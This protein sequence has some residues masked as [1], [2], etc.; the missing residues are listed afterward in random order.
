M[1]NTA[2]TAESLLDVLTEAELARYGEIARDQAMHELRNWGVQAALGVAALASASW[3]AAGLGCGC[4][5]LG[6]YGRHVGWALG[7]AVALGYWPYRRLKNWSLWRRHVKAV[8]A[9]QARRQHI[10]GHDGS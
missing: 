3:A 9:A 2:E 1:P 5:D 10:A 4:V 6:G 7:A 8:D